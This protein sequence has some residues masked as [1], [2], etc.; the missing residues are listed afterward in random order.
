MEAGEFEIKSL[1]VTV[2]GE[3]LFPDSWGMSSLCPLLGV[4]EIKLA[5]CGIFYKGTNPTTEVT[6]L[7]M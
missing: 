4:G 6:A 2:S 7:M 1:T 5:M 3:V